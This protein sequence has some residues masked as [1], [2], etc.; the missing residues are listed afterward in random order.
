MAMEPAFDA[1]ATLAANPD[2]VERLST[3]STD[4]FVE[5]LQLIPGATVTSIRTSEVSPSAAVSA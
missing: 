1:D 2:I 5:F 4:A 3:G